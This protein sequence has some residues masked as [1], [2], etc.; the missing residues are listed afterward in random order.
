MLQLLMEELL[1]LILVQ[2]VPKFLGM[3]QVIILVSRYQVL[4]DNSV[5]ST[6]STTSYSLT[7]SNL[8]STNTSYNIVIRLLMPLVIVP[9]SHHHLQ[10]FTYNLQSLRNFWSPNPAQMGTALC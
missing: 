1:S 2:E 8:S 3:L 7:T 10:H 5:V 4:V 9:Q 6:T